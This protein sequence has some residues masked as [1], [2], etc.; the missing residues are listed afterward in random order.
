M[1]KGERSIY[2]VR[3]A[4]AA[5]RGEKWPDDA[6]RPLTPDGAARMRD[7]VQGL[8]ALEVE[9]D[10]VCTS[11]LVRAT[12]TAEILVRGLSPKPGLL[13]VPALAPGS[14]PARMAEA[15]S[16]HAPKQAVAVVGHEPGL[17]EFA[18][19]LIGARQA[20]PLKKGG[21]IRI[22]V[23]EWPPAKQSG[24][25]IWAATPKMLRSLD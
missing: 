1:A 24:T 3:H 22:D 12:E 15:I 19:W 4:I 14:A 5:E 7:A 11:P 9:I 6:K 17:G 10:V 20:I 23:P 25:L 13:S 21:V 16:T 18:A 2:I 8:E